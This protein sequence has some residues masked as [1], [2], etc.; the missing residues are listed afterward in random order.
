LRHTPY[1]RSH[2]GPPTV[3]TTYYI[4]P[5]GNEWVLRGV[6]GEIS[7]HLLRL[8]AIEAGIAKAEVNK[9]GELV[10]V[11]RLGR[12]GADRDLVVIIEPSPEGPG[13]GAPPEDEP[14]FTLGAALQRA[15]INL[16][17]SQDALEAL[18]GIPK[19]RISRYENGHVDPTIRALS[20]LA[21]A[22]GTSPS[23][24]AAIGL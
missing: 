15:R 23:E 21:K 4:A 12:W 11:D 19:S 13:S 16:G 20:R 18:S 2:G 3:K 6:R 24:L 10:I 22:I 7:R 5:D 1:Q 14:V 9:P 8:E 17:L